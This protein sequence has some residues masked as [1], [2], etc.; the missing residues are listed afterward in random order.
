M[1]P[2]QITYLIALAI[3]AGSLAACVTTTTTLPDGTVIETTGPAPGSVE[4]TAAIAGI[5]ASKINAD[6]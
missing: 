4:S 2:Y 5:L 6:K 1:K 3:L